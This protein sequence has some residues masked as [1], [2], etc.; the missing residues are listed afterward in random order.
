MAAKKIVVPEGMLQAAWERVGAKMKEY[1]GEGKGN[2]IAELHVARLSVEAALEWLSEHP[3]TPDEQ[4]AYA[5]AQEKSRFPFDAW[6]WTRW[7]AVEWQR[8]M[9]LAPPEAEEELPDLLIAPIKNVLFPP[10]M[11]DVDVANERIREAYRR[12]QKAGR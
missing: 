9:F 8:R 3:I 6:E 4:Q 10:G 5:M 11:V 1:V 12:G 2:T 7:G